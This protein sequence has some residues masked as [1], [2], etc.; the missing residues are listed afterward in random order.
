MFFDALENPVFSRVLLTIVLICK[1]RI[2]K[3]LFC[4]TLK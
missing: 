2:R 3:A 4:R 1:S